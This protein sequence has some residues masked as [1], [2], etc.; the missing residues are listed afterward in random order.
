M[1]DVNVSV[2]DLPCR[3]RGFVRKNQ[4]DTFTIVL[5]SRLSQENLLQTYKHEL[6]HIQNGDFDNNV[7]A[8]IVERRA[9]NRS[10]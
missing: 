9:H 6:S 4:D 5:N 10:L 7:T 2:I 1:T 8:N 3:I